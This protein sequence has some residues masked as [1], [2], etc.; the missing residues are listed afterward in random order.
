MRLRFKLG[1]D[2][3][4]EERDDDGVVCKQVVIGC[5]GGLQVFRYVLTE[6]GGVKTGKWGFTG[7]LPS[8]RQ[9]QLLHERIKIVQVVA[10]A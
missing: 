4:D 7:N 10:K 1:N 5:R 8:N 9:N 3:T 6:H 2:K